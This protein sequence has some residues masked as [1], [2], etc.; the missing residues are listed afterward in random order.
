MGHFRLRIKLPPPGDPEAAFVGKVADGGGFLRNVPAGGVELEAPAAGVKV[1]DDLGPVGEVH[2]RPAD[3]VLI[4]AIP[5]FQEPR[6]LP[7]GG[8]E[9]RL[10]D[11]P[12]ALRSATTFSSLARTASD[13]SPSPRS[14]WLFWNA[15][16]AML[17][18]RP[19][20][21]VAG[22]GS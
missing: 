5:E 3:L 21:P 18:L 20:T 7:A 1:G 15:E 10:G 2:E 16:M 13:G 8:P 22:P 12:G 14:P 9:I 17:V 11:P 19:T 4:I 6:V